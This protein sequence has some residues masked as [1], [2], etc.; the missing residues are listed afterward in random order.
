MLR[1][2]IIAQKRFKNV[3][4]SATNIE[5]LLGECDHNLT[6]PVPRKV[7]AVRDVPAVRFPT[8]GQ[9]LYSVS[10]LFIYFSSQILLKIV[11]KEN[12]RRLA[13]FRLACRPVFFQNGSSIEN[14]LARGL[15]KRYIIGGSYLLTKY[16]FDG[17]TSSW[18]NAYLLDE[19]I[20]APGKLEN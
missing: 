11:S 18:E 1:K 3:S 7:S 14:Q 2:L 15:E 9:V 13:L 6:R 19:K 12:L 17:G 8:S 5:V 4:G 16:L 10:G 20:E